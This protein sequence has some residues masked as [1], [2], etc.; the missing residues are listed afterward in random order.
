MI[1]ALREIADEGY[2]GASTRT[3]NALY[4]RHKLIERATIGTP[5]NTNPH[6]LWRPTKAGHTAIEGASNRW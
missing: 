6:A 5:H 3:V 4:Y 2:T 1:N